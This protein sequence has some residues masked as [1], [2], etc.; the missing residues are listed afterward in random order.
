MLGLPRFKS[1]LSSSSA[2]Q[3]DQQGSDGERGVAQAGGGMAV[4]RLNL[5][6]SMH[7]TLEAR[8]ASAEMQVQCTATVYSALAS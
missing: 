8:N 2:Q 4:P 7:S 5:T 1:Q 6:H 3:A